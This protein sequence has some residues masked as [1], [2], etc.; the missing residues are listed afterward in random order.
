M[1]VTAV[2]SWGDTVDNVV[3]DQKQIAEILPQAYPFIMIDR[4]IEFEKDKSLVAVK[5]ITGNE[6]VFQGQDHCLYN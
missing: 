1:A 5:N 6:W 3:L 2:W 4:V